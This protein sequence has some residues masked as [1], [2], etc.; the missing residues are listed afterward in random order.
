MPGGR[1]MGSA[2]SVEGPAANGCSLLQP[3][4]MYRPSL[5]LYLDESCPYPP[6]EQLVLLIP[7][8]ARRGRTSLR[9]AALPRDQKG[10]SAGGV[11][12]LDKGRGL[13]SPLQRLTK[14]KRNYCT[15]VVG[16]HGYG[17]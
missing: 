2:V 1:L 11:E 13:I 14:Q 10:R 3:G 8:S 15:L 5:C 17:N 9:T 4:Q 6:M 16:F 12:Q 7:A